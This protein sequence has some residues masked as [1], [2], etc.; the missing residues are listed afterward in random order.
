MINVL[1]YAEQNVKHAEMPPCSCII[2]LKQA[3]TWQDGYVILI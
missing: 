3:T 1:C 2:A